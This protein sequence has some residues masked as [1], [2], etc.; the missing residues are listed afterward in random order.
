[1]PSFDRLRVLFPDHHGL[2]RGKYVPWRLANRGTRNCIT[3]FALDF[4][5]QMVPAPGSYFSEGMRDMDI[6]YS[7]EDVRQGW[8]D[9]ATAVV[10]ADLFFEGHPIEISPRNVLKKAVADWE[11]LGHTPKVGIELECYVMQ[12][13]G[14]GGWTEWDTP[15][16]YVYGTGP[17]V[18]PAGLLDDVMRTADRVG[19]PIESLNS[20]YDTP[21][22][23]MTL[24]YDDALRAVDDIFLYKVMVREIALKKGLLVTFMGKP[25]GD[26]GGSG[27]HVNFSMAGPDGDNRFLDPAAPYGLST[28][29]SQSIAGCLAHHEAMSA[30]CAPTVNAYKRLRPAQLSG[31]WANWGI[32]HRSCTLRVPAE[33]S[34][35]KRLEHRMP[36]GAAN[37]YLATAAVLQ[38]ARLGVVGGLEPPGPETHDGLEETNTERCVPDNLSLALDALEADGEFVDAMGRHMVEHWCAIKRAEWDKFIHAVTDWELK[39]YLQHL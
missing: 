32:D 9:D 5:R 26:R 39:H 30:I 12:P 22:F 8:D 33:N 11:A 16:A 7:M 2:A 1:M 20:E 24:E 27:F 38:A 19:L 23:E 34:P 25:F 13:D 14:R 18:D 28:L 10:V 36:D 37:P 21:Q 31:Y 17:F 6:T 35:A 4:D 15:G 3:L 29:A